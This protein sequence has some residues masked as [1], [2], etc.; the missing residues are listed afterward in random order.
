MKGR[1]A[2]TENRITMDKESINI[3]NVII[4]DESGSMGSIRD[5]ALQGMNEV[6]SGIRKCQKEFPNQ[7]HYVTITTFEGNGPEGV[8]YRR[9]R[10]P[11]GNISDLTEEDYVPGGCTPLYDAMGLTLTRLEEAIRPEDKVMATVITD[12]FENSSREYSQRSTKAL[13]ERLKEKGWTFG[14]IGANQDACLESEKL[15]IENA[16][17]FEATPEGTREMSCKCSKSILMYSMC[18]D[19]G[20]TVGN[21]YDE[22]EK[23]ASS[24]NKK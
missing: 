20:G 24:R 5:A 21:L 13:V 22:I 3:Y 17:N 10:I 1:F 16:M 9:D 2:L 4:L 19:E 23:K 11:I 6:I 12:G 18:M 15:S 8:K 7:K 14:Y